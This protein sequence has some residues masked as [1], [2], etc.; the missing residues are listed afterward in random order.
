MPSTSSDKKVLLSFPVPAPSS[1]IGVE[2]LVELVDVVD[3]TILDLDMMLCLVFTFWP[4][5]NV[6]FV[7]EDAPVSKIALCSIRGHIL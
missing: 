6:L 1:E 5:H 2:V 4:V 3:V 7:Q